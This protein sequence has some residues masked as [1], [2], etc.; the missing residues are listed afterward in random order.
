[1]RTARSLTVCRSRSICR[2]YAHPCTPAMH[3]P[4]HA[5]PP[6]MQAPLVC[7]PPMHAPCNACPLQCMPP[8]MHAPCNACPLATHTPS[9]TCPPGHARPPGHACTPPLM[10]PGSHTPPPPQ[11]R[12]L[13]RPCTAPLD[14][15]TDT[16]KKITLPQLRCGR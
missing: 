14:R 15:I 3:S 8:V 13:P 7:T 12:T 9:H 16:C 5:G 11:P 6:G 4:W 2:G 1:M 10:F